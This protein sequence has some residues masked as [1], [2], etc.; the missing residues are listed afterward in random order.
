MNSEDR[1]NFNETLELARNYE[2]MALHF[3]EPGDCTKHN[4]RECAELALGSD[5]LAE[6]VVHMT[7]AIGAEM[8][9]SE[10]FKVFNH[11]TAL[12]AASASLRQL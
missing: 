7:R 3:L 4:K 11:Y 6:A 1:T 12:K 8:T 5:V 10:M 9:S 2:Q